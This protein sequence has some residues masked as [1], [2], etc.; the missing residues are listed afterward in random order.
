[1]L[2]FL[3]LILFYDRIS[4]GVKKNIKFKATK[5]NQ[6]GFDRELTDASKKSLKDLRRKYVTHLILFSR[7]HYIFYSKYVINIDLINCSCIQ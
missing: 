4:S 2:D 6:V 7:Y 3:L 1:M 5:K